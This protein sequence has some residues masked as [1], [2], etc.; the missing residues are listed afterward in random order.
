MAERLLGS[1]A[2]DDA[3]F[4]SDHRWTPP[5]TVDEGLAATVAAPAGHG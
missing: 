4:R 1:L 2:V 5:F 3:R